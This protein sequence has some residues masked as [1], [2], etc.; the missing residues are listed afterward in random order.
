MVSR[1]KFFWVPWEVTRL[2]VILMAPGKVECLPYK[3]KIPYKGI[4]GR[5]V[6]G[7]L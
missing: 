6:R 5:M 7:Q 1:H 2:E 3:G 4:L